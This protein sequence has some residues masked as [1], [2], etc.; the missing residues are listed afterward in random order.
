MTSSRGI[1]PAPVEDLLDVALVGELTV[2][3]ASGIEF[4]SMDVADE[5]EP[6]CM[7]GIAIHILIAGARFNLHTRQASAGSLIRQKK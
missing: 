7:L 4:S 3:D 5:G 6:V 2:V 1:L